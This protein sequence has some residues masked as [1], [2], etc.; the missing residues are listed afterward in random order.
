[1]GRRDRVWERRWVIEKKGKFGKWGRGLEWFKIEGGVKITKINRVTYSH[2]FYNFPI[3]WCSWWFIEQIARHIHRFCPKVFRKASLQ[4]HTTDPFS[5]RHIH[6][7]CNTIML[8]CFLHWEM[9]LNV[10]FLIKFLDLWV[11]VFRVIIRPQVSDLYAC[12]VLHLN[13]PQ[14]ELLKDFIFLFHDTPRHCK[15][16]HHWR[17]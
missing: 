1:L 9:S 11:C 2:F 10:M 12:L 6:P 16:S 3:Q 4:P 5:N 7:L 17:S 14:L 13:L 15:K 8:W